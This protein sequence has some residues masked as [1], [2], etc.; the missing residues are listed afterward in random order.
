MLSQRL[1]LAAVGRHLVLLLFWGALLASVARVVNINTILRMFVLG[2]SS[3]LG[4]VQFYTPR[5]VSAVFVYLCSP[6]VTF[7][8]AAVPK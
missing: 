2:P 3:V 7:A 1:V 6:W 4:I 8:P 5:S